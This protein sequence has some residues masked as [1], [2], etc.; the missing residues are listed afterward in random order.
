MIAEPR[1]RFDHVV[2]LLKE[3][4]TF[5]WVFGRFPDANGIHL[6]HAANPPR[7][8]PGASMI[9][10]GPPHGN[11]AYRLWGDD[12]SRLRRLSSR[13]QFDEHDV[14]LH[15]R[16]ARRFTLCD[17]YFSSVRGPSTP[18][19]LHM[20][21][22]SS[23]GETVQ[24]SAPGQLPVST[25]LT[26]NPRGR[27]LRLL[28][29][30]HEAQPPYQ[31]PSVP[32]RLEQAGYSWRN[33]GSLTVPLI[34]SLQDAAHNRRTEDFFADVADQLLP[35]FSFLMSPDGADESPVSGTVNGELFTARV[36]RAIRDNGYWHSTALIITWDDWG[37]LFDHVLPPIKERRPDGSAYGWGPRVPTLFVSPYSQPGVCSQENSHDSIPRFI[38]DN[39]GLVSAHGLPFLTHRDQ[40]SNGLSGCYD[41]ARSPLP[42][43]SDEMLAPPPRAV[44]P[45]RARVRVPLER[46]GHRR[47][48]RRLSSRSEFPVPVPSHRAVDLRG[49]ADHRDP[50]AASVTAATPPSCGPR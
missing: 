19:Y 49:A 33:Y 31:M 6:R 24:P 11:L 40:T 30:N 39:F 4:L 32:S 18:N 8:L 38:E 29:R 7:F 41:F 12:H 21:A 23:G 37:G 36:I 35:R 17:N 25:G 5:D 42:A 15:Y 14:W 20:L 45:R 13:Q 9:F 47:A 46:L 27:W 1:S 44:R 22:A 28:T 34:R 26:N 43:P 50:D 16:L 2:V 48:L 10:G 3:N